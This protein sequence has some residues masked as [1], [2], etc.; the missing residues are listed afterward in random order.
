[1]HDESSETGRPL[2]RQMREFGRI[3]A[4]AELQ[5]ADFFVRTDA[6]RRIFQQE[7]VVVVGRKG[8]GKT[9]IYKA[10]QQ[11]ST[12][13]ARTHVVGLQFKNYPWQAHSEVE[14]A[15]VAPIERY[16]ESW[17]FLIL[18]E[19][20]KL[21]LLS[22]RFMAATE[23]AQAARESVERFIEANWGEVQFEFKDI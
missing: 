2:I 5:L 1:M 13:L 23:R 7:H 3:D 11:Q 21:A 6:Y 18:V 9:A 10:L 17:Q 16:T 4:E 14:D 20:A 19:L 22:P 15:T 8:T 12:G